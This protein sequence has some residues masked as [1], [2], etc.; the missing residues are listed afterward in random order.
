[1]QW[2]KVLEMWKGSKRFFF[3]PGDLVTPTGDREIR[4]S[5]GRLPWSH[6]FR[7]AMT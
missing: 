7:V 5:C 2:S 3:F 6:D 4:S 1:M